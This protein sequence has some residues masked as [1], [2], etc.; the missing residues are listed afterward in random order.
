[1]SSVHFPQLLTFLCC[2]KIFHTNK[3][4]GTQNTTA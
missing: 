3:N 2:V 1:M 4:H